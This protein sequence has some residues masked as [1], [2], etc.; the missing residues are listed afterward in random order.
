M[1]TLLFGLL[2]LMTV[3]LTK[4][5]LT[6]LKELPE[7]SECNCKPNIIRITAVKYK[8]ITAFYDQKTFIHFNMYHHYL[9]GCCTADEILIWY[10]FFK[11]NVLLCK[12]NQN[13]FL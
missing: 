4:E 5:I 10:K 8:K 12:E 9:H 2:Q 3:N 1:D 7:N 6:V 11:E 13:S